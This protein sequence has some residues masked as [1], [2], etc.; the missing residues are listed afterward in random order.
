MCRGH[1][2]FSTASV[3]EFSGALPAPDRAARADGMTAPIHIK[4]L[5]HDLTDGITL[6]GECWLSFVFDLCK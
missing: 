6:I 2:G 1:F 5:K 3:A 4:I